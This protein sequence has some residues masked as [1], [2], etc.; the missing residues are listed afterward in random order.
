MPGSAAAS[1]S[2]LDDELV[3]D[4]VTAFGLAARC[5]AYPD[6]VGYGKDF[7]RVVHAWRPKLFANQSNRKSSQ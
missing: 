1:T 6:T 7:E 2:P 4:L 5:N 3:N